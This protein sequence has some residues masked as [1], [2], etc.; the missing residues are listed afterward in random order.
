MDLN[1]FI[2]DNIVVIAIVIIGGAFVIGALLR[3]KDWL[4]GR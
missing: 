1:A 2:I 3:F 4:D